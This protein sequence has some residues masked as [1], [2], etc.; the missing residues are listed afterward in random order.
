MLVS[1]AGKWQGEQLIPAEYVKQ[2]TD[3]IHTNPQGTSYGYF[4]WRHD[5]K[6]ENGPT[7]ANPA[8]RWWPVSSDVTRTQS[9]HRGNRTSKGMGKM[10]SSL[11]KELLPA[12]VHHHR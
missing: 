1:N 3:R 9:D 4:W 2:A 10:L 7:I 12:F 11:P 8:A 6:I 5:M